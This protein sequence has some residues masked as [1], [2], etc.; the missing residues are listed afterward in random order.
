MK[1]SNK[2]FIISGS[3]FGAFLL[4]T[5]LVTCIDVK[6]VGFDGTN[7]GFADFNKILLNA[8]GSSSVAKLLSNILGY[9]SL[10][11]AICFVCVFL[12]QWIKRKSLKKID[13][14]LY[15]LMLLYVLVAIAY[16]LFL[17]VTINYR[18]TALESSYPS[19][20][21]LLFCS[22]F[23]SAMFYLNYFTKNQKLTKVLQV[24]LGFLALFGVVCRLLSGVHW[25]TDII[26]AIVL[27]S[28]LVCL[29]MALNF[30]FE[31]KN[32]AV[33]ASENKKGE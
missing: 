1:L 11:L 6:A 18:P 21:T 22:I 26:G 12:Y 14:K 30:C 2:F 20:H 31:E 8:F 4:F 19:S 3:L 10:A 23:V 25:A 32:K 17:F 15:V 28:A 24:V 9:A 5:I 29:L 7:I 27:S 33:E 16:I 13:K